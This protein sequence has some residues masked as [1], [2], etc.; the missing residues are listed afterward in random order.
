MWHLFDRYRGVVWPK[1]RQMNM[2]ARILNNLCAGTGINLTM[3]TVPSPASPVIIAVDTEWMD[4]QIARATNGDG[5]PGDGDPDDDRE[6]EQEPNDWSDIPLD[7][8][9]GD[10]Y[11]N[12][13]GG[14]TGGSGGPR[15]PNDGDDCNLVN[16]W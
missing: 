2:I 3:P 12:G 9:E 4:E 8:G 6:H 14:G 16:D 15:L 11:C 10:G 13:W 1:A 7:D 5:D